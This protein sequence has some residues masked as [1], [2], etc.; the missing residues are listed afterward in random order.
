LLAV[1]GD[2]LEQTLQDHLEHQQDD[3]DEINHAA[4]LRGSLRP[5]GLT[6]FLVHMQI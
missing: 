3:D 1:R 4:F 5:A 2:A 6:S